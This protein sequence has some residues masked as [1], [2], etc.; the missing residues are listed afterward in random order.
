MKATSSFIILNV[1][2]V[3]SNQ[4]YK[5]LHLCFLLLMSLVLIYLDH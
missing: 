3:F 5:E 2:K 1:L 4:G